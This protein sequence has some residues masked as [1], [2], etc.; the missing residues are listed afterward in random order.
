METAPQQPVAD[1][2]LALLRRALMGFPG[3]HVVHEDEV[4]FLR[5]LCGKQRMPNALTMV[6]EPRLLNVEACIRSVVADGIPGDV[7]EAG[8]WRGGVGIYASAV[9][10]VLQD[11]RMVWL[12]D[13]GKHGFPP[14]DPRYPEDAGDHLHERWSAACPLDHVRRFAQLYGYERLRLTEGHFADTLPTL[15]VDRLAILRLDGDTFGATTTTLN[16][17]YDKLVVG[18]YLIVDDYAPHCRSAAAVDAFRLAHGISEPITRVDWAGAF[19][20]KSH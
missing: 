5:L 6:G 9:L 10:E 4:A 17:L 14:P 8:C 19:W 11:E 3:P 20:R 7:L 1:K 15:P 16:C 18:G 12:C 2:Y 13:G